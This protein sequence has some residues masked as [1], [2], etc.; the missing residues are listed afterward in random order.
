MAGYSAF[1]DASVRD[2]QMRTTQWTVGKNFDATGGFG[3][4]LVT[5]DE[6]PPGADGLRVR[7]RLNGT[8]MQ[9]GDTGDMT[10]KVA[11]ITS[12]NVCYTKLLRTGASSTSRPPR[13]S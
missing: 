13:Y 3:P 8:T 5:A 12:Y 10:F 7:A 1:N 4:W 11:R 6:L 9:D 2:Y